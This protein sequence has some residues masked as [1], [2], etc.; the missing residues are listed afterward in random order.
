MMV[1]SMTMTLNDGRGKRESMNNQQLFLIEMI[2]KIQENSKIPFAYFPTF[3]N[4][5]SNIY[6]SHIDIFPFYRPTQ[7]WTGMIQQVRE[8]VKN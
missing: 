4:P 6:I 3:S 5:Y 1:F 8:I 2:S 7:V